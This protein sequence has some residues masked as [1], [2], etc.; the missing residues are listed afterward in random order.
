M[1][2]ARKARYITEYGL[3]AYEADLLTGS[4]AM[5]DFFEETVSLGA[6]PKEVSNWM[7][8]DL[9]RVLKEKGVELKEMGFTPDNLAKLLTLLRENKINRNT[10][11]KVF[12]AVFE[13]NTDVEPM[14][15]ITVWNRSPTPVP[16]RRWWTRC[17]KTIQSLLRTIRPVKRKPKAS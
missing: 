13:D 12:Q 11:G 15:G 7:L 2:E 9:L 4:K 17:C 14:S 1:A 10:A 5:V 3:T 8:D 16:W 6:A